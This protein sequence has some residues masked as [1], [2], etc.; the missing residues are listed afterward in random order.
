M[1]SLPGTF[2]QQCYRLACPVLNCAEHEQRR[3]TRHCCPRC[4]KNREQQV[5]IGVPRSHASCQFK[6][7]VYGRGQKFRFV[8][9]LW[10]N[11]IGLKIK[12]FKFFF[13]S[14]NSRPDVC[15]QCECTAVG[16]ECRRYV[17]PVECPGGYYRP[18]VS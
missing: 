9:F 7:L 3:S 11:N 8:S 12:A 14:L 17:C 4:A 6:H 10:Y 18:Q 16:L 15:S 1:L 5:T 13:Q 2:W